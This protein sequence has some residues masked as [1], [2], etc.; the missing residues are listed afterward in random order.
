MS[1]VTFPFVSKY[2]TWAPKSNWSKHME[3]L[4][5][6]EKGYN[7]GET[8]FSKN[9]FKTKKEKNKESGEIKKS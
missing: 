4:E 7:G 3:D 5:S 1:Q 6:R 2:I 9:M 8:V